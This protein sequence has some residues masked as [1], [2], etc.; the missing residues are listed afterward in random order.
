MS[1]HTLENQAVASSF[2]AAQVHSIVP[3]E[4]DLFRLPIH[5]RTSERCADLIH[6]MC[7]PTCTS[8]SSLIRKHPIR[9]DDEQKERVG[10][11]VLVCVGLAEAQSCNR[12][13]G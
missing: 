9:G 7:A 3:R 10:C 11:A 5:D 2:G 12:F 13:R 1:C 4:H 6:H 8:A